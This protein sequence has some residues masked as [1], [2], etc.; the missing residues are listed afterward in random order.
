MRDV[1]YAKA[2][3]ILTEIADAHGDR[4]CQI[5]IRQLQGGIEEP[6]QCQKET[7]DSPRSGG[8]C[9]GHPRRRVEQIPGSCAPTT[10]G[11]N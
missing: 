4:G 6:R 9:Q 2:W 3:L 5:G 8:D 7:C 11:T 1:D 10:R